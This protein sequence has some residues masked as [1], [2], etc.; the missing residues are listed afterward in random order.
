M[1]QKVKE[2]IKAECK[3]RNIT[4]ENLCKTMKKDRKYIYRI[5]D[6]VQLIK[7]I[8]IAHAIGCE[9]SELLKGT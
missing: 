8:N 7:I 4:I 5:T 3:A 1:I 6:K 2:N 9:P